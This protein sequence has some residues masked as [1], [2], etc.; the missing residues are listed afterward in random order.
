M[1]F[2]LAPKNKMR[3]KL[4][5]KYVEIMKIATLNYFQLNDEHAGTDCYHRPKQNSE[6][7]GLIC[8]REYMNQTENK[9]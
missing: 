3:M 4:I 8:V 2:V 7:N 1:E 5:G 9:C 6:Q